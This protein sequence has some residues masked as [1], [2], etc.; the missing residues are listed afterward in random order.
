MGIMPL[1]PPLK[2]NAVEILTSNV[3]EQDRLELEK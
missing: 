1:N 2:L 3:R